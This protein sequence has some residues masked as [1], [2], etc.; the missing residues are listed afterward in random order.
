M[1]LMFARRSLLLKKTQDLLV[2]GQP[3][4][5]GNALSNEAS[6]CSRID[7]CNIKSRGLLHS[8]VFNTFEQKGRADVFTRV[9]YP[10][11]IL[12]HSRGERNRLHE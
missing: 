4:Q 8:V 2:L 1:K 5:G 6:E 7:A 3:P 11:V 10:N 12:N 9:M